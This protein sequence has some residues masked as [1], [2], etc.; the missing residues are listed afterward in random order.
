MIEHGLILGIEAAVAGGRKA[1]KNF[2][3]GPLVNAEPE[4]NALAR[5][6]GI[7]IASAATIATTTN[8]RLGE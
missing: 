3:A 1:R 8:E 2:R 6:A 7:A 4:R 5:S